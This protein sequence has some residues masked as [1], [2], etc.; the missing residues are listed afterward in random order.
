ML[1]IAKK[2]NKVLN[3]HKCNVCG[4]KHSSKKE[5]IHE[6]QY[7]WVSDYSAKDRQE[8]KKYFKKTLPPYLPK[9]MV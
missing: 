7:P 2:I 8:L 1:A 5:D 9:D 6:K 3:P 4:E